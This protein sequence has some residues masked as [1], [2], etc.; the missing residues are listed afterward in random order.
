M[1]LC[2]LHATAAAMAQ[3][4]APDVQQP[5]AGYRLLTDAERELQRSQGKA[6]VEDLRTLGRIDPAAAQQL[7]AFHV[8][9]DRPRPRPRGVGALVA[10]QQAPRACCSLHRPRACCA[11]QAVSNE[12]VAHLLHA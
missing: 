4:P 3:S 12:R 7:V 5:Q 1:W 9:T 2:C 11:K 10:P 6:L 8:S